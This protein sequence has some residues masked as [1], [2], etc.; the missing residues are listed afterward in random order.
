MFE[1]NEFESTFSNFAVLT[2]N[3]TL[4]VLASV[5]L[6]LQLKNKNDVLVPN[7]I[8]GKGKS[9]AV[10]ALLVSFAIFQLVAKGKDFKR[11]AKEDKTKTAKGVFAGMGAGIL[12]VGLVIGM[13]MLLE[14][15]KPEKM[16]S[17]TRELNAPP[18]S[19]F[20]DPMLI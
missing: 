10:V 5:Q 20:D 4:V 2:F 8:Q 15:L 12:L 18:P 17:S 16:L 7:M 11:R 9:I 19:R 6:A 3:I 1:Y 14:R 13:S